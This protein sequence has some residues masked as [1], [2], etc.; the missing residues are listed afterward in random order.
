MVK[1]RLAVEDC[2]RWPWQVRP[3][4]D[5]P[6]ERSG[7]HGW[8]LAV[9]SNHE[10]QHVLREWGRGSEKEENGGG[11][12][13]TM[14]CDGGDAPANSER[15]KVGNAPLPPHNWLKQEVEE[16]E[17]FKAELWTKFGGLRCDGELAQPW[18]SVRL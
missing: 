8:F 10:H 11:E 14:D 18:G 2:H 6:A 9:A 3:E 13:A 7:L 16:V 17:G 12:L 15:E 4:H 5:A 1:T